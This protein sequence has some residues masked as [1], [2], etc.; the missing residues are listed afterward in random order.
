MKVLEVRESTREHARVREVLEV[1]DDPIQSCS[2]SRTGRAESAALATG[3]L[4]PTLPLFPVSLA[5]SFLRSHGRGPDRTGPDGGGCEQRRRRRGQKR[6]A[7]LPSGSLPSQCA[8]CLAQVCVPF[9]YAGQL[10]LELYILQVRTPA[11]VPCACGLSA[12]CIPFSDCAK[13][14]VRTCPRAQPRVIPVAAPLPSV[15][16]Q[17]WQ[18]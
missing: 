10:S 16:V 17:M 15:P 12:G 3:F 8:R 7:A 18:G 14:L 4:S 6:E 5:R 9:V 1:T 2:T 13:C 11:V